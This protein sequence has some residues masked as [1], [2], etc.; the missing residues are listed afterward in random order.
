MSLSAGSSNLS[1]AAF[2]CCKSGFACKKDGKESFLNFNFLDELKARL[3]STEMNFCCS[4]IVSLL[5]VWL[6]TY[7]VKF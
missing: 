5:G 7:V 6:V 1:I 4:L 2:P 3:I